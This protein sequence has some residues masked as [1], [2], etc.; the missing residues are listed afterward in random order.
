MPGRVGSSTE[1]LSQYSCSQVFGVLM[2]GHQNLSDQ[3]R[4]IY[5]L[6]LR[7][8]LYP[9]PPRQGPLSTCLRQ[10]G[11]SQS[12]P[13]PQA[14]TYIGSVNHKSQSGEVLCTAA[15]LLTMRSGL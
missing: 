7:K 4:F 12:G 3:A 5:L 1:L 15:I 8:C 10:V 9:Y 14:Q 6:F 2:R 13:Q 11:Y